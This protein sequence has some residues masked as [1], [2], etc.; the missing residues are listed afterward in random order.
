[1]PYLDH[2]GYIY[3]NES[4]TGSEKYYILCMVLREG[5][6]IWRNTRSKKTSLGNKNKSHKEVN[7]QEKAN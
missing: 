5:H 1:M 4:I 7:R 6:L 3:S 2:L